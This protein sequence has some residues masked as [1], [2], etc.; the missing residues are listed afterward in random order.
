MYQVLPKK[1]RMTIRKLNIFT[2]FLS[3]LSFGAYSQDGERIWAEFITGLEN[4]RLT[5]EKIR[6]YEQLGEAYRPTIFGYL[7]SLRGK[8]TAADWERKPEIFKVGSRYHFITPW[9]YDGQ[10]VTFCMTFLT[11]SSH[12]YFQHLEAIF[13]RL[14]TIGPPPLS[15]FPD[16]P[17]ETKHWIRGEWYW[18]EI[19]LKYYLPISKEK[20][21]EYALNM[22]KDGAGYAVAAKT[23]VPFVP[24]HRAFI[25]YMCWEQSNLRGNQVTLV[26]LED[27]LAVVRMNTLFFALYQNTAHLKPRISTKEYRSIFETIWHDRAMHGDWNLDI[28]YLENQVVELRFG[29]EP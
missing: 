3:C 7:D 5:I 21:K 11:D 17:E 8:A 19:I 28:R 26:A 25:L 10:E 29:R 23:W 9:T 20:G 4:N 27:T 1:L 6:P 13:I 14:D 2:V 18:S 22:L 16:I 24:P 15:E 12:W